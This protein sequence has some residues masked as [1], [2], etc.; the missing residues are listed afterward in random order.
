M[1]RC[2]TAELREKEIKEL[3]L[4]KAALIEMVDGV[5]SCQCSLGYTI[6]DLEKQLE[7]FISKFSKNS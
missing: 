7:K 1:K 2:S 4:N 5:F 3:T 6:E